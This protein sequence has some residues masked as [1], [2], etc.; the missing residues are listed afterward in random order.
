MKDFKTIEE[1]VRKTLH[2]IKVVRAKQLAQEGIIFKGV[3][4]VGLP[5]SAVS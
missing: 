1:N 2:I 3:H 5:A 4:H